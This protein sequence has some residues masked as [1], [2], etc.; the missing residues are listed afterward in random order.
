M[1]EEETAEV[2]RCAQDPLGTVCV[3]DAPGKV[4]AC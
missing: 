2:S 4:L 1:G 3:G